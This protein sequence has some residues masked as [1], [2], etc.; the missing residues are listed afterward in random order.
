MKPNPMDVS[1]VAY[2]LIEKFNEW[3]EQS[4]KTTY[5][6]SQEE[7]YHLEQMVKILNNQ[8]NLLIEYELN[9]KQDK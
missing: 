7:Q 9:K 5:R 4:S 8:I 2:Y 1:P 6:F 3:L